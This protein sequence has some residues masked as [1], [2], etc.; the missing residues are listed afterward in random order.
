[1][2]Q[3]EQGLVDSARQRLRTG[4]GVADAA[5]VDAALAER[6]ELSGEQ[7]QAVRALTTSGDGVQV[8]RAAAGTGKTYALE[9][10]RA[11]WDASDQ[12]VVG[13]ALSARAARE[14]QE[15]TAIPSIT[16][17]KLLGD[18][19]Q[20]WAPEPCHILVVDEAGM[21]GTRAMAQLSRHA[22]QAD[23]KLVLVGDDRQLPEIDAGG[24]LAGISKRI[25]ALELHDV[26]RQQHEWDRDALAALRH[27]KISD[28][29]RAYREHERIHTAPTPGKV[30]ER[31]V[32]DWWQH[33]K[34]G[35]DAVM[36]AHRRTDVADLN[37]RARERMH[38]DQRLGDTELTFGERTF[39]EGDR[40]LARRND[41]QL[42]V[43]N[44]TRARVS[45]VD[46]ERR[47]LTI[48]PDTG[49]PTTLDA[50]YLDAGHLDHAYATTAHALQG[51]SVDHAHVLGS[52][53]LYRE[54]GY[55]ALTR[56]RHEAHFYLHPDAQTAHPLP[57]LQPEP[58]RTPARDPR[59][60]TPQEPR[61]RPQHAAQPR[62]LGPERRGRA[63]SAHDPDR[64]RSR[65]QHSGWRRRAR[66]T[67]RRTTSTQRR[68]GPGPR[69][70]SR[71]L[72]APDQPDWGVGDPGVRTTE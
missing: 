37:Q 69:H 56:H 27:G 1:M 55:T 42:G 72:N 64:P 29:A 53:D 18:L 47:S 63:P 26:R 62:K 45:D 40:V 43:T 14:L 61:N 10:A 15:Q 51:A 41:H 46:L 8:L 36:I 50:A 39:A 71:P 11:A 25:G 44:G 17:A 65:A 66:W 49:E 4:A 3:T 48:E 31:M 16:I 23:V 32:D 38:A 60:T 52:E 30:R 9:A 2:L 28:W 24:A 58:G 6:P 19:S 5:Q 33:A 21:V 12:H 13:C 22:A 57:G 59:Q 20:G 7:Q 67:G 68:T 34:G 35:E 70:G 54:W